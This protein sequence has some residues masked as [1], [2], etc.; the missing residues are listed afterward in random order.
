MRLIVIPLILLSFVTKIFITFRSL[1]QYFKYF[2]SSAREIPEMINLNL[3]QLMFFQSIISI[4]NNTSPFFEDCQIILIV[5]GQKLFSES[6]ICE[7]SLFG[8][9]L[10]SNTQSSHK[11]WLSCKLALWVVSGSP[12]S[13]SSCSCE[14]SL[15]KI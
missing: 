5:Q 9:I 10:F 7:V 13:L 2:L 14:V 8:G 3:D 4:F 11:H 6:C 12:C 1:F 15:L